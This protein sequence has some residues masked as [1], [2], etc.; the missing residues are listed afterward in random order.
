VRN[1]DLTLT[2][3][4]SLAAVA[5][6]RDRRLKLLASL[7]TL[8]LNAANR[9]PRRR[10]G[11]RKTVGEAVNGDGVAGV[12]GF[13][14]R[15]SCK[16]A[17]SLVDSAIQWIGSLLIQEAS[18][19]FEVED[20][21]RGLQQDLE[22]MQQYLQDADAKQEIK[23]IQTLIRQI[24]NLAYDAEDVIDTYILE[25][26]AKFG[27]LGNKGMGGSGKSTLARKLY[28]H[29]YTKESFDCCAWVYISQE[30]STGHVLS[31]I[32]RKV[33]NPMELFKLNANSSVDELVD[34]LRSILEKKSYLVVLDDVWR[35]EALE[36]ILP[37]FPRN[38]QRNLYVHAPRPLSEEDS[39]VLFCKI[40]F[41]YH[42]DCNTESYEKLG[43]EMLKKC[44]GLPLA[45]VALAGI[46]NTKRSIR[47]WQQ[48][49][50]AVRSRVMEGTCTHMYGKVGDMLALS[51]DDL[52]G[53]LKPCFLYLGVFP[54]DCQIPAGM[55]TRMWI[56][57]GFVSASEDMPLKM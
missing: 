8:R 33:S 49:N 43:K 44:D 19:L 47:E 20:L 36:E 6:R 24:R 5:G 11:A 18:L 51:Y 29:P 7:L 13:R 54:E 40:A 46:L 56:A 52:P 57:E 12:W 34:K 38:L 27:V 42:T 37:A 32:L 22:L 31:E 9:T 1:E 55:L 16:M 15:S 50:E 3:E 25:V 17:A 2:P 4:Q 45:I 48:V 28:N 41:N 26:A 35:K 21:V 14:F 10:E 23:E 30:W 53:N 39:W